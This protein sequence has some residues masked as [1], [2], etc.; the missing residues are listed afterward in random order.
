[1]VEIAVEAM[2]MIVKL[3]AMKPIHPGVPPTA[4]RQIAANA[5]KN[6]IA[7]PNQMRRRIFGLFVS[8]RDSF[9]PRSSFGCRSS[10]D[11]LASRCEIICFSFLSFVDGCL[12]EAPFLLRSEIPHRHLVRVSLA[13][14]TF[15]VLSHPR[16]AVVAGFLKMDARMIPPYGLSRSGGY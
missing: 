8:S 1:M 16:S 11:S 14:L 2:T 10:S 3:A 6:T 4:T 12:W 5:S 13:M 15:T 7:T 9:P